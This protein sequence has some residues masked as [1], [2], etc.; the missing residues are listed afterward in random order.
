MCPK[1]SKASTANKWTDQHID[2]TLFLKGPAS[3]IQY[4][5]LSLSISLTLTLVDLV[6]RRNL[7]H[8]SALNTDE[9]K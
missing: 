5:K 7:F 2:S 3:F 9:K 4:A 8:L 1:G 6:F